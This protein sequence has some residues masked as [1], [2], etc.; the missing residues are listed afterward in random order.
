MLSHS[1]ETLIY[2]LVNLD[3]DLFFFSSRCSLL[4]GQLSRFLHWFEDISLKSCV[5]IPNLMVKSLNSCEAN[6][7]LLSETTTLGVPCVVKTTHK[8]QITA[9]VVVFCSSLESSN[10]DA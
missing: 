10:Q 6:C 9:W 8:T 5:C 4:F 2:K 7:G 1:V 3:K